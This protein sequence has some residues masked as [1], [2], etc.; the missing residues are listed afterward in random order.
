MTFIAISADQWS[1]IPL[2]P[3]ASLDDALP[4]R[5]G[6]GELYF[7]QTSGKRASRSLDPG[8]HRPRR[9]VAQHF[10]R[11]TAVLGASAKSAPYKLSDGGGWHLLAQPGG[12]R[13]WRLRYRLGEGKHARP[14]FIPR[15]LTRVSSH[16]TGRARQIAEG[17]A[18]HRL[19]I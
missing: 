6:V 9:Q 17:F 8:L 5:N 10:R 12:S 14:W 13:L 11:H 7:Q 4:W 3:I 1:D 16:Q 18:Y 19:I 2:V 15:S